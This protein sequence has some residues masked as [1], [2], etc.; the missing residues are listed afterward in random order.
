MQ[1][2][3]LS[4]RIEGKAYRVETQIP[5]EVESEHEGR[6]IAWDTVS[7]EVV[8]HGET[9]EE[10]IATSHDARDAGRLIWSCREIRSSLGA[11]SRCDSQPWSPMVFTVHSFR[12]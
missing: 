9:L 8:G 6:W 10:A 1:G 4:K 3:R 5:V 2:D 12:G 7:K 11:S